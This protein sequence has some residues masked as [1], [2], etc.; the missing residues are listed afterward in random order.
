MK[1]KELT[2]KIIGVFFD[3]YNELGHGF[4]ESV[5]QH[6]IGSG[7][8]DRRIEGIER[9]KNTGLVSREAGR[10]IEGDMMV[11]DVVLLELKLL[12]AWNAP[13]LRS[14]QL[15]T[16]H[17]YRGRYTAELWAKTGIQEVSAR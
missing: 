1:H 6:S 14:C 11:E 17:G 16:R 13:T 8:R 5:Y 12:V 9:H 4:L 15:P 2:Y 10:S 3:V 7:I